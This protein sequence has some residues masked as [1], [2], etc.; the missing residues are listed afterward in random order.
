MPS[1]PVPAITSASPSRAIVAPSAVIAFARAA[2]VGAVAEAEHAHRRRRQQ[3]EQQ[4]AVADRLVA[5][6]GDGAV[7]RARGGLDDELHGSTA[8]DAALRAARC[9][10]GA[11]EVARTRSRRSCAPSVPCVDEPRLRQGSS[12]RR[13]RAPRARSPR[14]RRARLGSSPR[15]GAPRPCASCRRGRPHRRRR[16]SRDRRRRRPTPTARAGAVVEP[17]HA[18]R[19]RRA[20]RTASRAVDP[21]RRAGRALRHRVIAQLR[22]LLGDRQ[23]RMRVDRRARLRAGRS[24]SSR[25][26]RDDVRRDPPRRPDVV[27]SSRAA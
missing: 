18:A 25:P 9:E 13:A 6:D 20:R 24:T 2:V 12:A 23:R 4:R 11:R 3:R 27:P 22:E 7:Q 8:S 16:R 21:Q 19:A 26:E 15:A 17:G 1:R 14:A 10:H 5:G